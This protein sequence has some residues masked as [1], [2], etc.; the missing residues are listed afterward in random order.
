MS[1][2]V[3]TQFTFMILR[4]VTVNTKLRYEAFGLLLEQHGGRLRS[5]A[6]TLGVAFRSILCED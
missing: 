1:D 5:V 2:G 4:P 6:I 3:E